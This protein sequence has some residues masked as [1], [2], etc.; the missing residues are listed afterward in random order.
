VETANFLLTAEKERLLDDAQQLHKDLARLEEENVA[1]SLR[2]KEAEEEQEILKREMQ[3][4]GISL[5]SFPPF[6]PPCLSPSILS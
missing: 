1:F 6:L 3:K 2:L 4:S 5:P